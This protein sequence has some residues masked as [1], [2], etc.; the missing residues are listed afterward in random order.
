MIKIKSSEEI[1]EMRSVGKMTAQIFKEMRKFVRPGVS[2]KD[3]DNKITERISRMGVKPAFLG[4]QGFPASA[5][6]SLNNELIHGIPSAKKI[7]QQGDLISIDLGLYNGRFYSD[8]TDSFCVGKCP[9]L[10]V[11]L[12]RIG[13]KVLGRAVRLIRPGIKVGDISSLI[14]NFVES[15]GFCVVKKFVGHGIGRE[16]HEEPEIPNFGTK[17]SGPELKEG[18]VLAIEPMITVSS[19]AVE[20]LD[21]G[22][23]VVSKDN[24]LCIH[25][26]H[27]VAVT[28]KGYKILTN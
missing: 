17:N 13:R 10:A 11:K 22:W 25:F 12:I 28:A 24:K 19:D 15:S 1:K 7:V 21:N 18:M 2:T 4:Y 27:S 9:P 16:L 23:T 3:I 8:A 5:C 6:I 14:E 20:I 26:E